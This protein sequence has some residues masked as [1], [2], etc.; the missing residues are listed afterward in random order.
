MR[1]GSGEVP[2]IRSRFIDEIPKE[3]LS[4]QKSKTYDIF[5]SKDKVDYNKVRNN[6]KKGDLVRHKLYGKGMVLSVEGIGE[7]TK[8]TVLFSANVKKKFIQKYAN[9]IVL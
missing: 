2:S 8:V 9:L 7:S 6:L 3:L 4:S 1:F 5:A